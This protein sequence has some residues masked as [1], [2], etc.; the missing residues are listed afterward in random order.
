MENEGFDDG[1][2]THILGCFSNVNESLTLL[3]GASSWYNKF[4]LILESIEGDLGC[5]KI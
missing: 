2:A 5:P 3:N 1:T 4:L